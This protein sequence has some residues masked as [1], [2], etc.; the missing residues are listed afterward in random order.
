MVLHQSVKDMAVTVDVEGHDG[1]HQHAPKKWW[2]IEI[3]VDQGQ[4]RGDHL[5]LSYSI[6]F[7]YNKAFLKYLLIK[8]A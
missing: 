6:L 5:L 7:V 3:N 2:L 1:A 8:Y 4:E